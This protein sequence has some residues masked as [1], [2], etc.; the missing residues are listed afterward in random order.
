MENANILPPSLCQKLAKHYFWAWIFGRHLVFIHQ[1]TRLQ[2]NDI[3][4]K[5]NL[6]S[7]EKIK[8]SALLA[9]YDFAKK[10][11][12]SFTDLVEHTIDV[13]DTAPFMQ[14][15][16]PAS[17]YI[18]EKMYAEIDRM[19]ELGIIEHTTCPKW[20]NPVIAVP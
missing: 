18:Q 1:L 5:S 17:P 7:E 3:T 10:D 2:A 11:G 15:Q 4:T 9:K 20:L 14:K 19:L 13:G 16:Y 12:I 6:S 8:L